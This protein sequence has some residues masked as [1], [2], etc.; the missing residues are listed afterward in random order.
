MCHNILIVFLLTSLEIISEILVSPFNPCTSPLTLTFSFSPSYSSMNIDTK[1]NSN[2]SLSTSRQAP[3]T[4]KHPVTGVE[5]WMN[6]SHL[7][8]PSD[9]PLS[10]QKSLERACSTIEQYPKYVTY[11]DG[12]KIDTKDLNHVRSVLDDCTM[13]FDWC[14]PSMPVCGRQPPL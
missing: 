14:V 8:H 11:G 5:V 12:S 1:W 13:V 9:L 3:A 2:K 6:H 7:F 10:T 4:S